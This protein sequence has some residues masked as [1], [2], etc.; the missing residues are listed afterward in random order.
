MFPPARGPEPVCRKLQLPN[1][2]SRVASLWGCCARI[3]VGLAGLLSGLGKPLEGT[4]DN[5]MNLWTRN[6]EEQPNLKLLC[7]P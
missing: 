4:V 7:K 1:G 6:Q 2:N 3:R 5:P